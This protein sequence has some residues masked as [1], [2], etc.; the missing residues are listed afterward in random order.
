[1][2]S[3]FLLTVLGKGPYMLVSY[4]DTE[5]AI[6]AKLLDGSVFPTRG[7]GSVPGVAVNFMLTS[8]LYK[9][10]AHGKSSV[11]VKYLES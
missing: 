3:C 9:P 10:K 8:G 11:T 7:N 4:L 1:M 5:I 2:Q 6:G